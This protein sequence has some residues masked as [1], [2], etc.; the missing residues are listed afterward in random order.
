MTTLP[1]GLTTW[2]VA[3]SDWV[4]RKR[5]RSLSKWQSPFGVKLWTGGALGWVRGAPT[6]V[7]WSRTSGSRFSRWAQ[8]KAATV[9]R[10]RSAKT[11]AAALTRRRGIVL[12]DD[13]RD[14][15]ARR[16]GGDFR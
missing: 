13:H 15:G 10:T 8:P 1:P 14:I 12:A 6:K 16:D 2:T 4:T 3:W 9:A 7:T 11:S 5:T